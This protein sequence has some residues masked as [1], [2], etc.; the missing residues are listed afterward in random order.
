MTPP[1]VLRTE[2]AELLGEVSQARAQIEAGTDRGQPLDLA[3]LPDRVGR[4][5]AA[6]TE[7]PADQARPYGQVIRQLI[8]DLDRLAARLDR[9][10]TEALERLAALGGAAVLAAGGAGTGGAA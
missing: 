3:S 1:A 4:L 10:R 6:I 2:L 5:C 8:T 7:L 9:R